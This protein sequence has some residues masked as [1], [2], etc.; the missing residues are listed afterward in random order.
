MFFPASTSS[1]GFQSTSPVWGTTSQI[2]AFGRFGLISIHVP[3]VGDDSQRSQ[4]L[5]VHC[6]FQSTSPVWGTTFTFFSCLTVSAISIHVPRVGDDSFSRIMCINVSQFQSTSPAW[7][8]THWSNRGST[9]RVISIHVP[10]V[11][12]DHHQKHGYS[13][14]RYFNPRPPRGGRLSAMRGNMAAFLFQSTSPAW[15]TTAKYSILKVKCQISIHVPRVG[16][17]SSNFSAISAISQFQSTSPAWGTTFTEFVNALTSIISIH[18]PR[19]GDDMY[20]A[21]M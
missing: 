9:E 19:V 6:T 5:S 21:L 12:D 17:D 10:R 11:G 1:W 16:D 8:T 14:N 15:G 2:K 3:R 20:L 4:D 13:H 7:G 18:V